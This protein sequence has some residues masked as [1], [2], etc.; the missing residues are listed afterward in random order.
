MGLISLLDHSFPYLI[1]WYNG[2]ESFPLLKGLAFQFNDVKS[3]SSKDVSS[4]VWL[5][6][7]KKLKIKIKIKIELVWV[8]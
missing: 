7:K 8:K 5:T 6:L 2:Y 3:P 4:Q 1:T